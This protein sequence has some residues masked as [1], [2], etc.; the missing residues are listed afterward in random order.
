MVVAGIRRIGGDVGLI[1]VPPPRPLADDEVLIEVRA[2]G[3]GNWDEI[4]RTGSWD[5]GSS[6]PMALGV[7]A[8]GVI[9]AVGSAVTDWA[10]GDEVMTHPLPL[11]DQG[12]W[13]PALIA[14]AAQLARKPAMVSWEVAAVFPIPALTAAQT[15][16]EALEVNAGDL[17]LVN[18]AGGV[19][20]RL[21]VS[22][23]SFRGAEVVATS[24]RHSHRAL[25]ALGA[26]HVIDGHDADW[27]EQVLA[28]TGGSGVPAAVN[29]APG[30]AAEAIRAVS[31]AGRL[32]T[33][34]SDPPA[35]ERAIAVSNLYV[36]PDGDQ[37]R[38][39]ARLL[40]AGRLPISRVKTDGLPNAADA[41]ATVVSG[42]AGGPVAVVL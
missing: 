13:A 17:L 32:A 7:E 14:P 9:A 5:V 16:D 18:G 27:V 20:G 15:L 39:L 2:A 40:E 22:L 35:P 29:A 42:R 24:G 36:R 4:V 11:R 41:L 26:R 19:T 3:V 21:L 33:I 1:D 37:L 31:D 23:A 8:A 34:T 38:D 6:P 10:P 30:G 12:T 25:Q 28:I